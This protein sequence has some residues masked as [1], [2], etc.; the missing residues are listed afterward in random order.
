M[1]SPAFSSSPQSPET[2]TE[3]STSPP[4]AT[5]S[6]GRAE[7]PRVTVG[8]PRVAR[9]RQTLDPLPET[10]TV[11]DAGDVVPAEQAGPSVSDPSGPRTTSSGG[12]PP[13]KV[14][15]AIV[16]GAVAAVIGIVA[17]IAGAVLQRLPRPRELRRPTEDDRAA[18]A[19]PLARIARRH[20]PAVALGPDLLDVIDVAGATS[21]YLTDGPLTYPLAPAAPTTDD[22][23]ED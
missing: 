23:P 5:E 13:A 6:T 21:A 11:E 2:T 7:P 3:E 10:A 22:T 12:E 1:P 19:A 18:I 16:A 17:T 20:A 9:R 4:P 15:P 8:L 14:D